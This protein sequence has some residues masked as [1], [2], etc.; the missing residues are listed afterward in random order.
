M[1]RLDVLLYEKKLF[2]TREKAKEAVCS[3][4]VKIND[5]ICTKPGEKLDPD[6][7]IEIVGESLKYVSRA[8]LKLEKASTEWNINF[9]D[10]VVIDIGA[11]T[12]GFTDFA[13]QNNAKLVYAVDVG[14]NQLSPK[15]KSNPKVINMEKTDFRNLEPLQD[16]IDIAVCDCSFISLKLLIPK[17]SQILEQ[18]KELVVLIKPQFE[19]GKT[20]AK[21]YKGIIKDSTLQ[22]KVKQEVIDCFKLNN[23]KLIGT[24]PSPILGTAG[25]KEFLAYF[26]KN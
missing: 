24:C 2:P 16:K 7:K 18:G 22:E 17:I 26:I 5:K 9:K 8:G 20:L 21:K 15:I 10:K 14:I 25:N 4:I 23:F 11:S 6:C 1:T 13:L 3:G 12:G 19:V